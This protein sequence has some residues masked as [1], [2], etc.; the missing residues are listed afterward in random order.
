M[1]PEPLSPQRREAKKPPAEG[2]WG[3]RLLTANTA[4]FQTPFLPEGE[5]VGFGAFPPETQAPHLHSW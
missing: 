1:G 4:L 5:R 3:S 2:E